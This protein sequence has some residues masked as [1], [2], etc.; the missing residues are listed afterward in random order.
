[1]CHNA[2]IWI[3]QGLRGSLVGHLNI[4][5]WYIGNSDAIFLDPDSIQASTTTGK[6]VAL[7][8]SGE[9]P[10]PSPDRMKNFLFGKNTKK[11]SF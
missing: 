10:P 1:M 6:V 5:T 4:T 8:G 2:K 7:S 3:L 9:A 11:L